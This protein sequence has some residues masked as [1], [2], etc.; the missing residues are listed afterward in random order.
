MIESFV[1]WS[2]FAAFIYTID[3]YV[4]FMIILCLVIWGSGFLKSRGY[5]LVLTGGVRRLNL[6]LKL[7]EAV[8]LW[9]SD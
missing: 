5:V 2:P 9:V 1:L 3:N 7:T 6:D 8:C 4:K